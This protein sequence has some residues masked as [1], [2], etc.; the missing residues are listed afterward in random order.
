[1]MKIMCNRERRSGWVGGTIEK[2]G[3]YVLD[4]AVI[5]ENIKI[6]WDRSQIRVLGG[7][8]ETT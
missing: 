3:L 4:L 2:K 7:L 5:R 8:G 1:M 6:Q